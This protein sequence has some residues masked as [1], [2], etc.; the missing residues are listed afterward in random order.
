MDS[1]RIALLLPNISS[2]KP[3]ARD[4]FLEELDKRCPETAFVMSELDACGDYK[5]LKFI[6]LPK[7]SGQDE[8]LKVC[9][10]TALTMDIDKV[11]TFESM[12]TYNAGW[13]LPYLNAGNVIESRKRNF[14]EMLASELINFISFNNAYNF[15]SMN[16]IFTYEAVA[17]LANST[18]GKKTFL[19]DSIN[20]LNSHSIRTTEIIRKNT[21]KNKKR[22]LNTKELASVVLRNAS[23]N[24]AFYSIV[25]VMT[26]IA[27]IIILYLGLSLGLIYPVAIFLGGELSGVSNFIV[28]EKINFK[29]KGFISS[30]YKFGRFNVLLMIPIALELLF[31]DVLSRYAKA[32][33][34]SLFFSIFAVSVAA[35]SI[36]SFLMI[37][38]F[39]WAKKTHTK[40]YI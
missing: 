29:N 23:K 31:L 19:A 4:A 12:S 39:I 38:R 34:A 10:S 24:S 33:G 6:K 27:N 17:V 9:F 2:L 35:V 11:I 22:P 37:N 30:A 26:Y 1:P 3:S 18:L 8:A 25:T 13:F 21:G 20:L 5:S 36:A 28:N 14:R 32:I 16:R 7:I 15:F 40:V